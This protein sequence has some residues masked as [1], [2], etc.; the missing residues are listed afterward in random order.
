MLFRSWGRGYAGEALQAVIDHTFVNTDF[1]WLEA[2]HRTENKKSGRVLEKS[3]MHRTETV[4]RFRRAGE[5]PEGEV[6]YR[7]NRPYFHASQTPG[8][9]V[10]EPRVSNHG[11]PLI[12]AS[13]KRENV[14]VY[15][16]NAVEKHCREVGFAHSGPWRKWA[17][18]GFEKGKLVLEEYWPDAT[19]ETYAGVGGY[20]Y[21]VEGDFTPQGEIPDAFTSTVPARVVACEWVPDAYLALQEAQE[22]GKIRLKSYAENSEK[23]LRWLAKT[24]R[25]EYDTSGNAPD[26]RRFLLDNFTEFC[27]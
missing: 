21:T 13:C 10:L 14:L 11:T 22:A 5:N 23:T 9:T 4:E 18:Y 20:I 3:A 8:L 2:Y 16:S 15:L 27:I 7:I 6:C 19:Y 1:A 25:Q 24:I 12:Y 17:S 26:Y